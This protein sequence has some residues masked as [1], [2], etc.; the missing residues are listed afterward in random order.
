MYM[1][2]KRDWSRNQSRNR[3]QDW[4][5]IQIKCRN[6]NWNC[7]QIFRFRNPACSETMLTGE[8][9]WK[10]AQQEVRQH[11]CPGFT[12]TAGPPSGFTTDIVGCWGGALVRAW[13]LTAFL[14]S[15]TGPVVHPFASRHEGPRF[16]PQEG[17]YVKPGFSC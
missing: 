8:S 1:T 13:N 16:N 4:N 14:H 5:H 17:T 6:R 10:E 3:S 12:L 2:R 15:S 7:L 11:F 9:V